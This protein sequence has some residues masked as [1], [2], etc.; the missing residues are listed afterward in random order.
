[1]HSTFTKFL[2]IAALLFTT[3]GHAQ[4]MF[5]GSNIL[6]SWSDGRLATWVDASQQY[7]ATLLYEMQPGDVSQDFHAAVD[8]NQGTMVIIE[9]T[10]GWEAPIL[11]DRSEPRY[12]RHQQL[13][14]DEKEFVDERLRS[15][16]A[17]IVQEA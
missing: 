16:S 2:V 6:D 12:P 14:P 15:I 3:A 13:R 1:M 8:G 11:N 5:D 9:T 10:D 7:Q 4:L 17:R